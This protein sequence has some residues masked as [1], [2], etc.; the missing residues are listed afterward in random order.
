MQLLLMLHIFQ[1]MLL[2][3]SCW[4][5]GEI[6][7]SGIWQELVNKGKCVS[8]CCS[9]KALLCIPLSLLDCLTSFLWIVWVDVATSMIQV[10]LEGRLVPARR[11]ALTPSKSFMQKS[12]LRL[13][14]VCIGFTWQ[15]FGVVRWGDSQT[16]LCE[17]SLAA[18]QCQKRSSGA[19]ATCRTPCWSSVFLKW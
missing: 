6:Y 2:S 12:Y 9:Q 14:D 17:Q 13:V 7:V 4:I 16:G 11:W 18:A 10:L 8:R 19:S 1:F 5:G 3:S 15:D